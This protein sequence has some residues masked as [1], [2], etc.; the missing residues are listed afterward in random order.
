MGGVG[1]PPAINAQTILVAAARKRETGHNDRFYE[2][3]EWDRRVKK[4]RARLI[5]AVDEAFIYVRRMED[6]KGPSVPMDSQEAAQAVFP[7]LSRSLQKYLRVTRQQPRHTAQQVVDH[8]ASYLSFDMSPRSFLERFFR[9]EETPENSPVDSQWSIVSEQSAG[10]ALSHSLVFQLR[11]HSVA[12]G[13]DAGVFLLVTVSQLPYL[14]L[15]EDVFDAKSNQFVLR[16]NSE[17]SV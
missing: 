14:D 5:T 7:A 16:L 10:R 1:G 13:P 2:E 9:T 4:R 3:E 17:T 11:C 8:L 15:T 6:E 12:P